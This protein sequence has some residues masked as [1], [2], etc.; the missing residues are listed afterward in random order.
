MKIY[1]IHKGRNNPNVKKDCKKLE[2][3]FG[4][5][6]LFFKKYPSVENMSRSEIRERFTKDM[7]EGNFEFVVVDTSR[8]KGRFMREEISFA[9]KLKIPIMEVKFLE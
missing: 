4:E 7:E 1:F 3:V 8:G 6:Y 5:G 9:K 2:E